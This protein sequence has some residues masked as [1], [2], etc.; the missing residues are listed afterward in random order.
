MQTFLPRVRAVSTPEKER[1]QVEDT[2]TQ[3]PQCK[4]L[5]VA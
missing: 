1:G 4:V 5:Y 2:H 3:G